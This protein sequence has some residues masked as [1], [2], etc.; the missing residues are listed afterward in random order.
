[1][2]VIYISCVDLF[3]ESSALGFLTT[4]LSNYQTNQL[5]LLIPPTNLPPKQ[6]NQLTC[7][8]INEN[9]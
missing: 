7:L 5:N 2:F 3:R 6:T 1:M 4:N 8:Q 9:Q